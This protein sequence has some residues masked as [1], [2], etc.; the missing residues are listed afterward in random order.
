MRG[1]K[2][3]IIPLTVESGKSHPTRVRGLK[4]RIESGPETSSAVSHPT[5]VRG[6]KSL[7]VRLSV[8]LMAVAPH[9]GAWIEMSCTRRG[10]RCAAVAPHPGA[11]IEMIM[12]FATSTTVPSHPTRVRGLKFVH[13]QHVGRSVQVAPHPGAWIEIGRRKRWSH[14]RHRRTPPGCVD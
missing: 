1:L 13:E 3:V 10:P 6:L 5:R 7:L 4:F 11:W 2:L 14:T 8:S 12:P 9:P